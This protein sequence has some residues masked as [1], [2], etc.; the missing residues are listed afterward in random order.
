MFAEAS[1]TIS[2]TVIEASKRVPYIDDSYNS[3]YDFWKEW[4][5]LKGTEE[6]PIWIPGA[7]SDHASFIFHAGVPVIDFW[8]G[9]DTKK[10]PSLAQIGYPAYHTAYETFDLMERIVDPGFQLLALSTKMTLSLVR[11]FSENIV[12]GFD[13]EDYNTIMDS[14]KNDAEVCNL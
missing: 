5:D 6:P 2:Q 13:L 14:F 12:L 9:P 4:L 3:Y 11:D 10:H 8:F 7:G 1:P